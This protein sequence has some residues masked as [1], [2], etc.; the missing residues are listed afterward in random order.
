M[1]AWGCATHFKGTSKACILPDR[2]ARCVCVVTRHDA[3][4]PSLH[5]GPRSSYCCR[6]RQLE[7]LTA[8]DGAMQTAAMCMRNT[9][10]YVAHQQTVATHPPY[11]GTQSAGIATADLTGVMVGQ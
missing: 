2:A 9:V 7:A 11:Q 10:A 5:R 3:C 8:W 4:R 6:N 1:S